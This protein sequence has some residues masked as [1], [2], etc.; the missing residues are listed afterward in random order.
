LGEHSPT[1]KLGPATGVFG[2]DTGTFFLVAANSAGTATSRVAQLTVIDPAIVV[3]PKSVRVNQG[4]SITLTVSAAGT[5]L[6]YAW[7]KDGQLIPRASSP[8]LDLS[9]PT[10]SVSGHY[11]VII[12]GAY[13]TVESD[14]VTVVINSA[15]PDSAFYPRIEPTSEW[16][17][18]QSGVAFN[19]EIFLG[20]TFRHVEAPAREHLLK[21]REDGAIDPHFAP[22]I[23]GGEVGGVTALC[24]TRQGQLLVGGNFQEV[25][26]QSQSHLARL[27]QDGS[28]DQSFRPVIEGLTAGLYTQVTGIDLL[29]DGRIVIAGGF[30][31]VNG[32]SRPGLAALFPDGRLDESFN[33]DPNHA[34]NPTGVRIRPDGKIITFGGDYHR[35]HPN[36]VPDFDFAEVL[37]ASTFGNILQLASGQL[38]IESQVGFSEQTITRTDSNGTPDP[39]FSGAATR[40][41][42]EALQVNG[43]FIT[44]QLGPLITN[45]IGNSTTI[46]PGPYAFHRFSQSGVEDLTFQPW[47]S[48]FA[49]IK[50]SRADGSFLVAGDSTFP[51]AKLVRLNN[52]E[53]ATQA[54][55]FDGTTAT[56]LR[57]GTSPEV[58]RTIFE[59]SSDNLTWTHLGSGIRIAGGWKLDGIELN[60]N[61]IL[62]VSGFSNGSIY[63][64]TIGISNG[65]V[66]TMPQALQPGTVTL[67][68]TSPISSPVV[69]Q[70]SSNLQ[71]WTD[72]YTNFN[73]SPTH[74][75]TLTNQ[76]AP[77]S[78]YRLRSGQ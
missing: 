24:I 65:I 61:G 14:V 37:S 25:N 69:L 29:P 60:S 4:T 35:L 51:Q 71:Q 53:P 75:F 76:S 15:L 56:W 58:T 78:F 43:Q 67:N 33:P 63:D 70:I 59:F 62:R 5:D 13:G 57:S 77:S 12:T 11:Q 45:V 20:G 28:L 42:L 18:I 34:A 55:T 9:N 3:Q 72:I 66:L 2:A 26:G 7:K 6:S 41:S 38:L 17:P 23:S 22:R 31:T 36:G 39:G 10:S 21:L 46:S 47:F 50:A 52:T 68:A 64:S 44:L 48:N 40:G 73:A 30:S 19:N 32:Q 27:D 8:S 1:L 54:L 74:Q 16:F 49:F